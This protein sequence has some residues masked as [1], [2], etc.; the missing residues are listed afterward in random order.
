MLTHMNYRYNF[1]VTRNVFLLW[2]YAFKIPSVSEWRLFLLG[3]LAN[4]QEVSFSKLNHPKFCPIVFYLPLGFM[5]VMKRARVMCDNEFDKEYMS[6]WTVEENLTIPCELKS[7]SF[8][9]L[10]GKI[11]VFDYGN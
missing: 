6:K 5:V 1:G 9:Y 4:M 11:V 2:N 8:G 10:D 7:D 3:L